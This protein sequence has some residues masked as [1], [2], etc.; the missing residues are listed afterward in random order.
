MPEAHEADNDQVKFYGYGDCSAMS[1]GSSKHFKV[2]AWFAF[3]A[4][5]CVA[6]YKLNAPS[7]EAVTANIPDDTLIVAA[8]VQNSTNHDPFY[9]TSASGLPN[10]DAQL[11]SLT[12]D[13]VATLQ[14]LPSICVAEIPGLKEEEKPGCPATDAM[15][16]LPA[17]AEMKKHS[18]PAT[19]SVDSPSQNGP[20]NSSNESHTFPGYAA[21]SDM[22]LGTQTW[23]PPA[24]Q[25]TSPTADPHVHP[26]SFES[27]DFA[28]YNPHAK[29]TANHRD[30]L[31]AGAKEQLEALD[32]DPHLEAFSRTAFPSAVECAKCHEQIFDEWASSSHAYAA[33]SPMFHVFENRINKLASGTIGYFCMRCHAPVATTMGLRRDQAIWDGPR[34]FREGVTCVACHRVKTP[35]GKTN[36][37]RHMIPGGAEDPIVG[38]SDGKGVHQVA[39]KYADYFK[40][41]TDPSSKKPGQ[42][43]H[44]RSIQFEEL[45]KSTYCVSCHQVAVEPGIKL[46][47]VWDQYRASPAYREGITCQQ[48]HMGAIPGV[49]SGYTYGP[50]A[51]VDG[52]VVNPERKHSNHMFYGPGYSIAHPGIFPQNVKADRWS[53]NEWLAFD[54]RAGWGTEAFEKQMAE[55]GNV[56]FPEPWNDADTRMD[57]REIVDANLEKLDYKKDLRVQLLENGSKLD[58]PFFADTPRTG[59]PL[60]FRYCLTNI[61]PGHNMPS[62]SL[63]A[64]PQIWMN[65]VLTGPSGQ[66]LWE[67]GYLDS[68]GDLCDNHS[69]DVLARKAP[70]DT[71]LMNLQTKFLV[72]NVK[73]TERE[74]YLPVPFELDQLPFIRPAPQPVT[75]LNHPVGIRME[76]HSLPP[77]GSRNIK[78]SVPSRLMTQPGTYTLSVRLRSR[79]EPIYFMRFCNATPEMIRM[80][81]EWIADFH[82]QTVVFEVR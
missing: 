39:E 61:N 56:H 20:T 4:F 3:I 37:E 19:F 18:A 82:E 10:P 69:L 46:E 15:A 65:A 25:N 74:M 79:A 17:Y 41:K 42:L 50:A 24:S 5:A 78:Y 66:R 40:T 58:G 35:Y 63:G 68:N 14:N 6:F 26:A 43:I 7:G 62:G 23:T 32:V 30:S 16:Q 2:Y 70:F 67:T 9:A 54:W 21:T 34:V 72:T 52:K 73:G 60:S 33:V 49:D 71:Q 59:E 51:V 44:R 81:N 1:T 27:T 36:G 45:S 48:C 28:N 57:A 64:Q 55:F 22:P 11:D 47:V 75:V 53:F 12:P 80:M 8:P 31:K 13:D 76:G 77:L 38:G 29:A